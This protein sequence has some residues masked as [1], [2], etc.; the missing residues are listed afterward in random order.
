MNRAWLS[1]PLVALSMSLAASTGGCGG[2]A[3]DPDD[4]GGAG[5]GGGDSGGSGGQ[6][7]GADPLV[8]G[9]C[10]PFFQKECATVTVPLS[11]DEPDGKSISVLVARRLSGVPDAPQLWLLEGGPGGSGGDFFAFIDTLVETLPGVDIY[12]LDHRGVG[13]STRLGCKGEDSPSGLGISGWQQCANDLTATWGDG[14]AGFNTSNAAH[15]LARL[16]DRT[17]A[18]G[19][20]VFVYGVSY[21]T[22]W[23]MRYLQLHPD[24]PTAVILDSIVSPGEQLLSRFDSQYDPV[25]KE[26][27]E[28]CK[29]DALC[30]S[31]LGPDP[32]ARLQDLY[33]KIDGGHCSQ[34]GVTRPILR[35]VLASLLQRWGGR[36]YALA[37]AYRLDRCDTGDVAAIATLFNVLYGKTPEYHGFSAAL[38]LNISFSEL[39]EKPAP[40]AAELQAMDDAALFSPDFNG[41]YGPVFDF[42]PRYDAGPITTAW[43]S[44]KVPVLVLNGTLDPQTP[45]ALAKLSGPHFSAP[46]QTFVTVPNS[47]HGVVFQSPTGDPDNIQCG[48]RILTSF[49]QDPE[50]PP[51]TSCIASMLPVTFTG[52]ATTQTL[53]GTSDLWENEA[54][55]K[56]GAGAA[57]AVKVSIDRAAVNRALQRRPLAFDWRR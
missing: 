29:A 28:L 5:G 25:A 12:T 9:D 22:Y 15:D 44:A 56:V 32:W 2:T 51:D 41:Y 55:A 35:R 8:W 17:R 10:P 11:Y 4:T 7:G 24:Q 21:G 46:H 43:P 36:A 1:I 3:D 34:L 40:T 38:Q 16:I 26:Y 19:Q 53:L 33:T 47:P 20:R 31:K 54:M 39:W 30:S 18:P 49:V 14:L 37:L 27:L 23:T 48:Q 45:Y 57:G 6:G 13:Q 42:W 52:D 50:A